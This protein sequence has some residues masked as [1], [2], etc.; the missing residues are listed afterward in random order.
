MVIPT[1]EKRKIKV[2]ALFFYKGKQ[3]SYPIVGLSPPINSYLGL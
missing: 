1:Q 2:G 3:I